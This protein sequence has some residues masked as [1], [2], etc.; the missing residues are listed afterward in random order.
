MFFLNNCLH[1]YLQ[2]LKKLIWFLINLRS[3]T[4]QCNNNF[5]HTRNVLPVDGTTD[6]RSMYQFLDNSIF[7]YLCMCIVLLCYRYNYYTKN[8]RKESFNIVCYVTRNKILC[9]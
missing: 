8:I 3:L 7:I 2:L 6:A 5:E 4:K 9:L 1:L